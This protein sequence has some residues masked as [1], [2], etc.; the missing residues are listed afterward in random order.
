ML[1][2][3]GKYRTRQEFW[4]GW[5]RN[6][7]NSD[8]DVPL[9]TFFTLLFMQLMP[10]HFFASISKNWNLGMQLLNRWQV[11]MQVA[12]LHFMINM[13]ETTGL[14]MKTDVPS[15]HLK[16]VGTFFFLLNPRAS[17]HPIRQWVLAHVI[18]SGHFP[19]D[20]NLKIPGP[21]QNQDTTYMPLVYVIIFYMSLYF[22][23]T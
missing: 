4:G 11:K 23:L 18:Y 14:Q 3:R 7:L 19:S 21:R 12:M 22:P 10:L 1:G 17:I 2:Y 6:R 15:L 8:A 9:P 16:R 13:Y 5:L 20:P